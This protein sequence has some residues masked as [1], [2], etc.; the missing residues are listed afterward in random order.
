M[1]LAGG[2]DNK[3]RLEM[4]EELQGKDLIGRTGEH[5]SVRR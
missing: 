5:V 3:L 1:D 2:M 4:I